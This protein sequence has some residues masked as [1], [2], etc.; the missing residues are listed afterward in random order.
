M[1]P[2]LVAS[3]LPLLLVMA[4]SGPE[5]RGLLEYLPEDDPIDSEMQA[6]T[7][8]LFEQI[9]EVEFDYEF[10]GAASDT[11]VYWLEDMCPEKAGVW[12]EFGGECIYKGFMYSCNEMYV[13]LNGF[14]RG[15][16]CG[17]S[18]VHEFAHCLSARMGLGLD[19]DHSGRIWE[20]VG[21]TNIEGSFD[22]AVCQMNW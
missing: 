1:I 9:V 6:A 22:W 12:L 18:L 5:Y 4:C 19:G 16:I 11:T 20:L 3:Y 13:A 21:E 15:K 10:Y 17:T 7:L 2:R 8:D 14:R